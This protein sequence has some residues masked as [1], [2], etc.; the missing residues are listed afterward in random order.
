MTYTEPSNVSGDP[1]PPQELSKPSLETSGVVDSVNT[2][3]PSPTSSVTSFFSMDDQE[4]RSEGPATPIPGLYVED[5]T[6]GDILSHIP[7][8]FRILDLVGEQSSGGI[9]KYL[10]WNDNKIC[11]PIYNVSSS[12]R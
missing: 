9:G 6:P 8:L 5:P 7:G 11:N 12:S 1:L 10:H 2:A 3:R 4:N